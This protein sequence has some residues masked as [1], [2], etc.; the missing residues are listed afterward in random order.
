MSTDLDVRPDLSHNDNDDDVSH[1]VC[2]CSTNIAL[3][4]ADVTSDP[5]VEDDWNDEDACKRCLEVEGMPCVLCGI[6]PINDNYCYC[7]KCV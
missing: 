6:D 2:C 5:L 7:G 4:G 3:C 1:V